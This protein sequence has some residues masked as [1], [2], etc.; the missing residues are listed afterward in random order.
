MLTISQVSEKTGLTPYT[1]RYYEKS[2]Y[3]M[4]PSVVMEGHVST[5]KARFPTFN[6]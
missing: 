2:G 3:Y 4:N 5:K 1:I 6:V